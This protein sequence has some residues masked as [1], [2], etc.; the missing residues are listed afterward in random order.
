MKGDK[1][2][3]RKEERKK[4]RVGIYA[5]CKERRSKNRNG[6]GVDVSSEELSIEKEGRKHEGR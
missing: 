5:R 4:G 2:R 3:F 6:E 1:E